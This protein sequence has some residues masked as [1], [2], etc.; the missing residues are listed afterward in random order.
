M[1]RRTFA[2]LV[3]SMLSI[4]TGV[5]FIIPL[6]P[7]YSQALGA[8][9]IWVGLILG[10]NPLMRGIFE[11]IFGRLADAHGTKRFLV[12]GL[13]AYALVAL[14]FL[15][16]QAPWQLFV[17]RLLQGFFGSMVE[18]VARAYAGSLT[19]PGKEGT[20]MSFYNLSFFAGFA[21]G[22]PMGGLLAQWVSPAAPFYGMTVLSTLA[23]VMVLAYVPERKGA[24]T[25]KGHSL[26]PLRVL[27]GDRTI[28]GLIWGR[29]F[30]AQRRGIFTGLF[31]L[32]VGMVG[33]SPFT[34]GT[35]ISA[36]S[37]VESLMQPVFGAASDRFDRRRLALFGYAFAP[38]AFFL[39]PRAVTPWQLAAVCIILALSGGVSVPAITALS[40][41]KG[42]EVGMG[43]IMGV[44]GTAMSLGMASGSF[45]GGLVMEVWGI[46]TSFA[47]AGLLSFLGML[48][49]AWLTGRRAAPAWSVQA[50][51]AD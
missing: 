42:R 41:D 43:S 24:Y 39:T 17:W 37:V 13:A 50:Q 46:G 4:S 15:S 45:L 36:R 23:L 12:T 14:G 11:I 19:P 27:W 10:A 1:D 44:T 22:P 20:V 7:A 32:W 48:G 31:P 2:A 30:L 6:L 25:S 38:L 9:G 3:T 47:A 51:R 34:A 28:Q 16:A 18:P 21:I 8:T 49:F 29:S 40:V 33:L 35:L 5:S 26:V